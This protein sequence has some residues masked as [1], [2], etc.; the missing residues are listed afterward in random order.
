MIA[1]KSVVKKVPYILLDYS[2]NISKYPIDIP[3]LSVIILGTAALLT[4]SIYVHSD[5]NIS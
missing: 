2:V 4:A 5:T 3:L 1:H